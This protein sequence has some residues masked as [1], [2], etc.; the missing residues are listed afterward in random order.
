MF[1]PVAGPVAVLAVIVIKAATVAF[2]I[3]VVITV[4]VITRKDPLRTRIGRA[5]PVSF[6]PDIAAIDRIP[7]SI[8]PGE[9]RTRCGRPHPN[10]ARRGRRTNINSERHLSAEHG[11]TRQKQYGKQ[12]FHMINPFLKKGLGALSASNPRN[13]APARSAA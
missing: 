2:P 1:P 7:V 4:A 12:F 13:N 6:M 11:S 5:R 9:L 3:A 10:H 8:Y